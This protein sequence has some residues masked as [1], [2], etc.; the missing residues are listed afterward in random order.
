[1]SEIL[2]SIRLKDKL[3]IAGAMAAVAAVL[4]I[5]VGL[6]TYFTADRHTHIYDYTLEME[7]GGFNLVGVCKV[8]NC[9]DPFYSEKNIQGVELVSSV[10]P[11]CVK[12]GNR[13]YSYTHNGYTISYTETLPKAP[14][15]YDYELVSSGENLHINGRCNVEGCTDPYIFIND[16]KDLTLIEVEEATC[17][18]P[19]KETYAFISGGETKTFVTL[20]KVDVPHTLQGVPATSFQNADKTYNYGLEGVKMLGDPNFGCGET[21][22][23][24][25]VCETCRQ[26]VGVN[27]RRPDHKYVKDEESI[28]KPTTEENGSVTVKCK[29]EWCSY[30]VELPLPKVVKG[31]N[32]FTKT[33]ATE[34]KREVLAYSFKSAVYN[35]SLTL[36]I[37]VGELLTHE[38]EYILRPDETN[39]KE[40]NLIGHCSQPGC[41]NPD[42]VIKNVETSFEDTSTCTKKGF[43]IWTHILDDGREVVL[44]VQSIAFAPHNYN[45]DPNRDVVKPTEYREGSATLTCQN[46]GCGHTT[47]VTLPTVVIGENATVHQQFTN[48]LLVNYTYTIE[49]GFKIELLVLV[50]R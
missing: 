35:F 27:V 37:E 6:V 42:I 39:N 30:E 7:D 45:F 40:I 21:G 36:D 32:A 22:Q 41:Q 17:F 2:N 4:A 19:R 1:M 18:T 25:Y 13:V 46:N 9:E 47:T 24:Y 14:H 44:K 26:A 15:T 38:Y 16:A 5:V 3:T 33:E 12:E 50:D 23:G 11:S 48:G 10:R 8:D 28:V 43:W 34:V 29:N 20:V 49:E 31:V